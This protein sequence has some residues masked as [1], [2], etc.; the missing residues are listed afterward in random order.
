MEKL[1]AQNAVITIDDVAKRAGVSRATAG[2]AI[3]NYGNVSEKARKKVLEAAQALDYHPNLIARGLR[4]NET[5]TIAVILGSIKNNYCNALVYAVEKEARKHGYNVMICNTYEDEKIEL[6]HLQNIYSRKVDGILLMS[7]FKADKE[8]PAEYRY[9]YA[10]SLPMVFVDRRIHG[11]S[12][13]VLQSKNAEVSF[14]ATDYLLSL[15]HRKIGVIGTADFSTILDRIAGY[16]DAL[17]KHGLPVEE[18]LIL[19]TETFGVDSGREAARRMLA[20]HP[21]ITAL[22]LLNNSLS[23]GT[24]LELKNQGLTIPKDLSLLVWDDEEINELLDITTIVQQVEEIGKLAMR[25]L[26]ELMD[27]GTA[28]AEYTLRQLDADLIIRQSCA[29]P[30]ELAECK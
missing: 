3:G 14:K 5:K 24:L 22:Y 16:R 11:I 13:D 6:Q 28:V 29:P 1:E 19:R 23:G 4:S 2:R 10:S 12:R 20:L 15:G 17:Q 25:R 21:D 8:I 18:S 7:A 26:F 27:Q 30:R 9:L